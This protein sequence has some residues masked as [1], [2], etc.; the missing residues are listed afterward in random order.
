M[1]HMYRKRKITI[2]FGIFYRCNLQAGHENPPDHVTGR[3][4]EIHQLQHPAGNFSIS[5]SQAGVPFLV[6]SHVKF[7]FNNETNHEI[8][9]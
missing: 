9:R 1:I 7:I 3:P 6:V 2:L 8:T 4:Q 5:L